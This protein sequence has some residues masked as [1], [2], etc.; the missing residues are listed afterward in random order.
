L[1]KIPQYR[2]IAP[3]FVGEKNTKQ[4]NEKNEKNYTDPLMNWPVRGL[5]YSNELGAALSEIAPKLGILL[6]F[7]AMLYFGADIY[8]KYKNE[9]TSYNPNAQRGTEQAIFQLLA[10]VILPTAAVITG[11]K[12]ASIMG[13]MGKNGLSLQSQEEIINFTQEFAS[14]RHFNKYQDRK[15]VYKQH[16]VESLTTKREKLLRETR[17]KNPI[18]LLT[19]AIF[20]NRHPEAIAMSQKEKVLNFADANINSMFD[21]YDNLINNKKPKEFSN[22]MWN[23]F[24]KLKSKY[25]KDPDYKTTYLR[26]AAEDIIKKYQKSK[27][28]NA[29]ILKTVGGFVALGLAIKPIDSFVEN[30]IIK[31]VVE[32]NLST[33]FANNAVKDYKAKTLN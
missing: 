33:M 19:S 28:Q 4:K 3:R 23:K 1:L 14:R 30:I 7:P 20:N 21:I 8:D 18:K 25:K 32:P 17:T 12:T 13:A 24:N 22:S 31:K 16:F 26:D 29:K 2:A 9:K 6:W 15:D 11:Q 27:M 5:A 10:S